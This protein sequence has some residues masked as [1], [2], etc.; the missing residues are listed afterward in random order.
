LNIASQKAEVEK[1]KTQQKLTRHL[2]GAL[3]R[4]TPNRAIKKLN[5]HTSL[6]IRKKDS[7][8]YCQLL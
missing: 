5:K 8:E 1:S 2:A 7:E 3:S 6:A 4:L